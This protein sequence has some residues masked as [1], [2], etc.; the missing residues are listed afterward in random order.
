MRVTFLLPLVFLFS[1]A[2][3]AFGK[4]DLD[5]RM[6]QYKKLQSRVEKECLKNANSKNYQIEVDGKKLKCQELIVITNQLRLQIDKEVE[7]LKAC[8]EDPKSAPL[9]LAA[10]TGKILEKADS[11]KPSPDQGQCLKQFGCAT[12][13]AVGPMKAMMEVAGKAFDSAALKECSGQSNSCLL[14][15]LRG[16]FDS[17]WSSLNL[18]WDLGKLAVTKTG[19]LFGFVKK[20]EASTSE[21]AMAAQQASPGFIDS[22]TSDPVGTVKTMA[23]NLYE[24]L[25]EAAMNH[26]GCEKWAGIPFTSKCLAPMSTWNCASCAQK[27]Q[28]YCGIAGYAVGEIGTALITGGLL[29]GGKTIILSSIKI[30]AGPAKNVAQFMSKTFP[31]AS[32]VTAKAGAKIGSVAKTTLTLAERKAIDT[33]GRIANSKTVEAI[34]KGAKAVSES[35]VGKVVGTG[36]K[37]ISV[38]LG[39]MDSAFKLGFNSVEKLATRGARPAVVT[40]EVA[41]GAKLADSAMGAKEPSI[42][43]AKDQSKATPGLVIVDT[44]KSAP[45]FA[46]T[47]IAEAV[48]QVRAPTQTA[49]LMSKS[50]PVPM[51]STTPSPV[52]S[53]SGEVADELDMAAQIAK[54]KNEQEYFQLFTS[55]KLYDDYH[56]DVAAVIM[57][58]ERT[59]PQLSKAEIKKSIERMMNSCDL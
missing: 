13:A 38:Y 19:E 35:I 24:S 5:E 10:A 37:P 49:N 20:S 42:K 32:S 33:W 59:Q 34:S 31:K 14:N 17:I 9:A 55:P 1:L 51:K 45:P 27:S 53:K 44:P 47:Q 36:L 4:S 16:I 21:R 48:A 28:V 3:Q 6:A 15:V 30:G 50:T 25:E 58:L 43:V 56:N 11:C 29:A 54:Y 39:A 57:T 18:V 12:M 46:K 26:Y 52:V 8:E 22:I 2:G 23:K 41:Q 40:Q 7:E